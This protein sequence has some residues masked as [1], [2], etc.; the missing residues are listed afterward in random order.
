[1]NAG[2]LSNSVQRDGIVGAEPAKGHLHVI[3]IPHVHVIVI[4]HVHV[5]VIPHAKR[6]GI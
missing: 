6:V 2:D 4:P 1:M 3:V 5:I